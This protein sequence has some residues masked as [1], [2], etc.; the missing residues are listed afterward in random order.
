MPALPFSYARVRSTVV[1]RENDKLSGDFSKR[2]YNC[3]IFGKQLLLHNKNKMRAVAPAERKVPP[4]SFSG[5][6]R[7]QLP[8][9]L[10]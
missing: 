9:P 5:L 8:T 10:F 7:K 2:R 3:R 1:F 4:L 6:L